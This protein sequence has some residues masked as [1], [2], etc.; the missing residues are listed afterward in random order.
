[1]EQELDLLELWDV[2]KRQWK[3]LL[4]IPLLAVLASILVSLFLIKPQYVA[5]ARLLVSEPSKSESVIYQQ[6]AN[7]PGLY[8]LKLREANLSYK[9]EEIQ[10]RTK[11]SYDLDTGIVSIQFTDDQSQ[12]AS[13]T[14]SELARLI[15][16]LVTEI[17]GMNNIRSVY[18]AVVPDKPSG[19]QI[20]LNAA[21]AAVL[22][23]MVAV[24]LILLRHGLDRT[25]RTSK[26]VSEKLGLTVFGIIP[27]MNDR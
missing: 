11:L 16:D 22:G 3:M 17:S 6:V 4:L 20:P 19:S 9:E 25:L 23:F 21:M 26:D 7:S 24:G 2:I 14:A 27:F 1:M 8:I 12:R 10:K 5:T 15:A 18:D 13:R